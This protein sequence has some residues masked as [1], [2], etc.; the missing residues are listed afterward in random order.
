MKR[1]EPLSSSEN[2]P[3]SPFKPQGK[4][5]SRVKILI[6]FLLLA[7]GIT[8]WT[9]IPSLLYLENTTNIIDQS[10]Q[11]PIQKTTPTVPE[12]TPIKKPKPPM[13][14]SGKVVAAYYTS[15]SIYARA[16][17]V[18][19]ID[20]SKLTHLLY[21]FANLNPNGEVFLGDSWADTDKHF[22]GDSWN[23]VNK[24]LYGNF[25]QLGLLK[26]KNKW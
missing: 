19:D 8:V 4:R 16:Y 26:K 17:N 6:A 18:V 1:Y 21:A 2:S 7:I 5:S 13:G 10:D 22:D 11:V 14:K 25:K 15:W 23:D 9:T 12:I 3:S 20:A 24:N